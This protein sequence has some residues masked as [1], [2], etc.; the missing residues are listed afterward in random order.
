MDGSPLG[1]VALRRLLGPDGGREGRDEGLLVGLLAEVIEEGGGG[2]PSY[3][4]EC[5]RS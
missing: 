4:S 2:T 1:L 5:F 3:T